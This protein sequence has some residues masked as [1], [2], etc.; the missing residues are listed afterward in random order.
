MTA[1]QDGYQAGEADARAAWTGPAWRR[2]AVQ[3][4][5]KHADRQAWLSGYGAGLRAYNYSITVEP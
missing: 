5:V 4:P 3:L 2:K 1:Y